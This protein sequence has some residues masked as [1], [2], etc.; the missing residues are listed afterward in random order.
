MKHTILLIFVLV[1]VALPAGVTG[2][3]H[4][5]A[6]ELQGWDAKLTSQM[7]GKK[8]LGQDLAK[9]GNHQAMITKRTGDGEAELHVK[10]VDVFVAE[11]GEAV[12][13]VG[14]KMV[15]PKTT[16]PGEVRGPSIE[17]GERVTMKVG[18]V[19][20]IPAN[21]PHQLLVKKEFLYFVVKVEQ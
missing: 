21:T 15:S 10:M 5:T 17:G 2:F 7:A 13:V 20:H 6:G 16:G 1:A 3:V 14:G 19:V 8:S 12:L 9:W 4:W 11:K 18:D